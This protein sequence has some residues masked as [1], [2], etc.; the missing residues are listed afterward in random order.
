MAAESLVRVRDFTA[1]TSLGPVLASLKEA[2]L[3]EAGP[4]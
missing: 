4:P 1:E 3:N 2:S